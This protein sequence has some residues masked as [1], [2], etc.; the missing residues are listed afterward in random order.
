[1]K[2]EKFNQIVD[3]VIKNE[4]QIMENINEL[5]QDK[6]KKDRFFSEQ[7]GNMYAECGRTITLF[8]DLKEN[9]NK[10]PLPEEFGLQP[11]YAIELELEE[12][13]D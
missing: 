6:G 10:E 5:I 4:K 13:E 8:T 11:H 12:D 1:M 3:Q 9:V 7:L 2:K